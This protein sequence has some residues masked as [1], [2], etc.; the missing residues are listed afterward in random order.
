MGLLLTNIAPV[1]VH[2]T[3]VFMMAVAILCLITWTLALR[4]EGEKI[5]MVLGHRWDPAAMERLT[6][7][8]D[9]INARLIRLSRR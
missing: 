4:G 3:D 6:G 1:L 9:A 2:L 5:T 7:Q 8:L